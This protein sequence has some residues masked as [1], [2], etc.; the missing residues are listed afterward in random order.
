MVR[1][2]ASLTLT[3][4]LT[5]TATATATK[6]EDPHEKGPRSRYHV[7]VAVNDQGHVNAHDHVNPHDRR[8]DLGQYC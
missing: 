6:C 5:L 4:A 3:L 2:W 1:F 8:S 7:A